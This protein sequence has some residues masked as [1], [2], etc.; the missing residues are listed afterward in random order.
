MG[1]GGHFE[2]EGRERRGVKGGGRGVG[3]GGLGAGLGGKVKH[4]V[5]SVVPSLGDG[6]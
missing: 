3:V 6:G 2:G 5:I 4:R 1:I